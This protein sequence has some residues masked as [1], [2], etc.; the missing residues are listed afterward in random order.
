MEGDIG[1][2][3]ERTF[4]ILLT[5]KINFKKKLDNSIRNYNITLNM[6]QVDART[7]NSVFL[8]AQVTLW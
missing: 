5:I 8:R 7:G 1:A 3:G 6:Q 2:G 4:V